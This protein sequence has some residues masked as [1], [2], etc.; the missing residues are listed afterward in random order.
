MKRLVLA[1]AVGAGLAFSQAALAAQPLYVYGPGGPFPAMKEAA[2]AFSKQHGRH[3][4][5]R[6][7]TE[8]RPAPS[9]SD[10]KMSLEQSAATYPASERALC[11]DGDPRVLAHIN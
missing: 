7:D 10:F 9:A 6:P 2:A 4:H 5:G 3:R 8:M 1:C 11:Q